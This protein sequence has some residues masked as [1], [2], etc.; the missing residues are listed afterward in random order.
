MIFTPPI[1]RCVQV[2]EHYLFHGTKRS[3]L[4]KIY[5]QGLDFR[6]ANKS[7]LGSGVYAAESSTKADQYTGKTPL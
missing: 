3:A 2:N 1:V 4:T 6:V 7:M 5:G